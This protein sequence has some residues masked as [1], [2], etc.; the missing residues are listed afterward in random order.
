L[1]YEKPEAEAM[2]AISIREATA[3]DLEAVN[4]IYNHYVLTCTCTYQTAPTTPE[5]RRAWFATHGAQHPITVAEEDG[6]VVGWGALSPFHTR[7][8]YRFT[9]EVSVYV[10]ED[11]QRRG[12]GRKLL[13]DL[14][15]R[16]RPLG[17]HSLI[18][19]IDREQP[20][21]LALHAALGFAEA[22]RLREV[23]FKFDRWLDVVYM[24]RMV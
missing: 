22:G 16:A 24:Q 6:T 11:R 7:E 3:A 4:A 10:R 23:G 14:I 20:G 9:A 8:A 12:I 17:Y 5:V 1:R 13:A 15:E 19:V 18:A 21:S 2:N